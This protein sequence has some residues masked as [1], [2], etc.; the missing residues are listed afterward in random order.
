VSETLILLVLF[1]V[2]YPY[3]IYPLILFS[4]LPFFNKNT[5]RKDVENL[6]ATIIVA[7]HNEEDKIEK[8]IG[9]IA[10]ETLGMDE[11]VQIIVVSDYSSD[12]TYK[13]SLGCA[14]ERLIA[15][16]NKFKRGKAEAHNYSVRFAEGDV[17]IFTDVDTFVPRETYKGM[18]GEF[19]DPEV[20]CVSAEIVYTNTSKSQVSNSVGVYWK[21]EMW[22][23]KMETRLGL[24]AT[25]SGPC[26]ALRKDAYRELPPTGDTDFTSPLH[27]VIQGL[28]C[29]QLHKKYAY[30]QLPLSHNVEFSTRVRMVSKNF[31]GTIGTWGMGNIFCHPIFTWAIFSHKVLRWLTPFFMVTLFMISLSFFLREDLV[32]YNLLLF[33][34]I[35]FYVFGLI[36]F[37]FT[38]KGLNSNLFT[39]IYSFLVVNVAFMYGILKALFGQVPS[40]Y[41]PT[42]RL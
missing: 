25:S 42:R 5:P 39:Q 36:G 32:F 24:C 23:R 6:T 21:F 27:V 34:Q 4:L 8:K 14:N 3:V 20:G 1:F 35:I 37:V 18:I 40:Y 28:K 2:V 15:L 26:M 17:L 19:R 30:D 11:V 29:V 12:K 9:D 41:T 31:S 13:I 22:L 7:A 33:S 16:E 38:K 10:S